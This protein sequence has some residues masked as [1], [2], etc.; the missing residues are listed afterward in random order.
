M[1]KFGQLISDCK[2]DTPILS[3]QPANLFYAEEAEV[4]KR[5]VDEDVSMFQK[6]CEDIQRTIKD[7]RRLKEENKKDP[8]PKLVSI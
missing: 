4:E 1:H 8:T 2:F 3:S 6:T 7:V 5:D